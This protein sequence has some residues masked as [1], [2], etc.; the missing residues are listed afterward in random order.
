M[1]FFLHILDPSYSNRLLESA[2]SLYVFAKARQ[3]TYNA[4]ISDGAKFYRY[5]YLI[6]NP[7]FFPNSVHK[8][9]LEHDFIP[10]PHV[11]VW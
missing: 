2:E 7:F 3:G 8:Y 5:E 6:K 9:S 11:V 4:D 1:H 10:L